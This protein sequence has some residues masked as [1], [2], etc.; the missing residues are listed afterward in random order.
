M[1]V[2]NPE[3]YQDMPQNTSQIMKMLKSTGV[4]IGISDLQDQ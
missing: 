3:Y 2:Y 1:E 4:E